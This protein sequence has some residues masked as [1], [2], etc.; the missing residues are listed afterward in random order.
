M[1]L[2]ESVKPSEDQAHNYNLA[3]WNVTYEPN[4]LQRRVKV[5]S[6][7]SWSSTYVHACYSLSFIQLHYICTYIA[8]HT[9]EHTIEGP[10]TSWNPMQII[11]NLWNLGA[12]FAI[13]Y[14]KE[15]QFNE[16]FLDI[17]GY[18]IA[19]KFRNRDISILILAIFWYR[20]FLDI[21]VYCIWRIF[22]QILESLPENPWNFESYTQF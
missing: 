18:Y 4:E 17:F 16:R 10:D 13:L 7:K 9:Y 5:S 14:L 12:E 22:I 21:F 1:L 11:W 15:I 6:S 19:T 20:I 2:A 8:I 3:V